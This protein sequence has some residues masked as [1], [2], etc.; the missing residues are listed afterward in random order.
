MSVWISDILP[1]EGA[2]IGLD[3]YSQ[4]PL[5]LQQLPR[6]T[7]E[8]LLHARPWAIIYN[9]E[10][11][12]HAAYL[13]APKG[14]PHFAIGCTLDDKG[15]IAFLGVY[16][17]MNSDN[18]RYADSSPLAF[19]D[20]YGNFAVFL[21]VGIANFVAS[22]RFSVDPKLEDSNYEISSSKPVTSRRIFPKAQYQMAARTLIIFWKTGWDSRSG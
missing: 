11:E 22:Q 3:F 20:F 9:D 4:C 15:Q 14:G 2:D 10:P 12:N 17:T 18:F 19:V 21:K 7:Q 1:A 13:V 6:V 5:L 8:C 16:Y